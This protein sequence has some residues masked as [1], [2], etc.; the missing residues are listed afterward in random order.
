MPVLRVLSVSHQLSHFEVPLYRLC[1]QDPGIAFQACYFGSSKQQRFDSDYDTIIDWGCSLTEG[2]QASKVETT[3]DVLTLARDWRADAVLFNGYSWQGAL[4]LLGEWSL[5]SEL[6]LIHRGTLNHH[7]DPRRPIR[8]RLFRAVRKYIFRR[9]HAHHYGGANSRRVLLQAGISEEALFFVPYSIDTQYFA[10]RADHPDEAERARDLRRDLGWTEQNKVLS[11]VAQHNWFKGPDIAMEVFAAY[12]AIDPEARFLFVGSGRE[13]NSMKDYARSH[14]SPG[15]YHFTGFVPS[16]DMT[17]VYLASD[18][19]V[20]TSRYETWARMVNEACLCQRPCITNTRVPSSGDLVVNGVS[21]WVV[22]GIGIDDYV[23]ALRRHFML[24]PDRRRR[25]GERAR[26]LASM[27]AYEPHMDSFLSAVDYS[28]ARA[29]G[30]KG[31][32]P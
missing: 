16:M 31:R 18:I 17:S 7:I 6:G 26:E 10:A 19:I 32:A 2:Y 20:C 29:R 30:P 24:S 25:M 12:Q 15:S 5:R 28:V 23:R 14:L 4:R 3:G 9:F 22:D 13:T 21:G 11:F 1:E 27:Y 8:G